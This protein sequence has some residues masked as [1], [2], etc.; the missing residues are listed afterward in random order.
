L[1]NSLLSISE[2]EPNDDDYIFYPIPF[3]S[4]LS[5]KSKTEQDFLS[6]DIFTI[7]GERVFTQKNY[8]E[9]EINLEFL[10]PGIYLIKITSSNN[11]EITRKIIKK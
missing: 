6:I 8:N 9:H 1:N 2:Y 5:W 10:K 3:S 4:T 7:E 11:N